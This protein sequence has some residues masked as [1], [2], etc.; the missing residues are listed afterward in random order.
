MVESGKVV[1]QGTKEALGHRLGTLGWGLFITWIGIVFLVGM[2]T[3][4]ALAG[5]GV[6]TLGVQL[7][8]RILGLRF[9]SFWVA[10][11][12]LFVLAAVWDI[13]GTTVRLLPVLLIAAGLAVVFSVLRR[14]RG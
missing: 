3:W 5:V 2:A 1:P 8:R 6:I 9:E 10:V 12:L 7:L 4:V 13:M 11:G 14:G